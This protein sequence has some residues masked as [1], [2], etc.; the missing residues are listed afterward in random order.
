MA[1]RAYKGMAMEGIVA[2]WYARSTARDRRRFRHVA[3]HVLQRVQPSD[4][5]LEVAPGPGYLAIEL[6][7]SGCDAVS[8]LDISESFVRIAQ[9]N[10][11]TA[12]VTVAFRRGNAAAMPFANCTFDFVVCMAAFKNFADPVGALNDIHRVLKPGGRALIHDLRRDASLVEIDR[13]VRGMQMS[14]VSTAITRWVF[15]RV[16]LKNAYGLEQLRQLVAQS[17]F[18]SGDIS[19]EG[20]GF[21]LW[22]T[23]DTRT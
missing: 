10:A 6:A 19:I 7:Q 12:G 21:A 9:E 22:L 1:A 20:V 2:T 4:R 11:R 16:L 15:R 18:G 23:R 8:G 5:I 3:R 14:A 17:R 13:E